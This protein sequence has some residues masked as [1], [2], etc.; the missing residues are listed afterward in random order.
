MSRRY[1]GVRPI[2]AFDLAGSMTRN[3]VGFGHSD[4]Y[5]DQNPGYQ[6]MEAFANTFSL[7][8]SG[9]PLEAEIARTIAPNFTRF[10]LEVIEEQDNG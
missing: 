2:V 3:K 6:Q 1:N 9:D 7:L 4:E 10:V 8:T 5:Y